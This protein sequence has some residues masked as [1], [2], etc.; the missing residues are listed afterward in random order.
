MSKAKGVIFYAMHSWI[1]E[2]INEEGFFCCI[3]I[4]GY[5]S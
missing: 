2:W 5:N 4:E 1:Y 3:K